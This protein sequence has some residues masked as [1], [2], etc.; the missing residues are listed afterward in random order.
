MEKANRERNESKYAMRELTGKFK[1]VVR[2]NENLA[3]KVKEQKRDTSIRE[4]PHDIARREID[5]IFPTN[6]K[7]VNWEKYYKF[8]ELSDKLGNRTVTEALKRKL[9]DERTLTVHRDS[10]IRLIRKVGTIDDLPLLRDIFLKEMNRD[11]NIAI[12]ARCAIADTIGDLGNKSDIQILK[13][14]R[15]YWEDR[16]IGNGNLDTAINKLRDKYGW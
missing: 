13:K 14:V 6:T 1:Q 5:E 4:T 12:S 8:Q 16:G 9:V 3:N 15:S 2:E 7:I 10:I 11:D